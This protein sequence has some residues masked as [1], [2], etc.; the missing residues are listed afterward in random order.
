M[1]KSDSTTLWF[2]GE[3]VK[4][5]VSPTA[6]VTISGTKRRAPAGPTAMS[7]LEARVKGR[8]GRRRE[9][10]VVECIVV[11]VVMVGGLMGLMGLMGWIDIKRIARC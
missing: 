11:V 5:R 9:R 3:K 4:E 7:M 1:R 2:L 6:A 10:R 8:M